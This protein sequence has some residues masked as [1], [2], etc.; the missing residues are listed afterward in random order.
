MAAANLHWLLARLGPVSITEFAT[1]LGI[2]DAVVRGR[3]GFHAAVMG[4]FPHL[5]TLIAYRLLFGIYSGIVP[6]GIA[7]WSPAT[8]TGPVTPRSCCPM[9]RAARQRRA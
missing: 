5:D 6:D 9:S 1:H 7:T 8:S 4:A 3:G 2:S